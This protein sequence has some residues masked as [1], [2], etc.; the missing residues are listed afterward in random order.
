MIERRKTSS[1]NAL[2]NGNSHHIQQTIN[3][4]GIDD[5][6]CFT[7]K[8]FLTELNNNV[9]GSIQFVKDKDMGNAR[10][11]SLQNHRSVL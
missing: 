4:L 3:G 7:E 9:K 6:F 11:N 5:V 8:Y 10:K 1:A 2:S